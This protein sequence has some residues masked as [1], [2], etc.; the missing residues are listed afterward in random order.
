MGQHLTLTAADNHQLGAY[1]ADPAAAPKGAVVVL[2]EIFGVN[3]HIRSVCDRFARE[4]YTA[5]A[6]ALF[7]RTERDFQSG[8]SPDEVTNARKFI[9]NPDWDAMLR[10]TQAAIDAVKAVGPLAVVGFCMGGSLAFLAATRLGGLSASVCYYGGKI[11]AFADETPRCPTQMHFGEVD[12]GIPLTDVEIIR[13]KRPDCEIY[14]Y[15][16]AGHGFHCDERASYH[17]ASADVA[18]GRTQAFLARNLK[19]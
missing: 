15:E 16:G 6:P 14:I 10:D 8:Y 12:G 7:D 3:S 18:W 13:Q 19:R 4:G 9:A 5:I 11:A 1:R 2:Q 17:A